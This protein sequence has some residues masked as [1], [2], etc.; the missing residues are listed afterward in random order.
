MRSFS[1]VWLGISLCTIIFGMGLLVIAVASGAEWK[2]AATYPNDAL[3]SYDETYTD[4]KSINMQIEYGEINLVEGDEFSVTADNMLDDDF[5]SYVKDGTWII[6]ENDANDFHIFGFDFSAKQMFRWNGNFT[7]HYTITIPRDFVAEKIVVAIGAGDMVV[8]SINANQGDFTLGAGRITIGELVITEKS[9]YNVG[10]GEMIFENV[11]AN[12]V[13]VECGVGEVDI[14]G[15]ITGEN[16]IHSGVGSVKLELQGNEDDYTYEVN[17]GIGS[18]SI[19]EN[20]YNNVSNEIINNGNGA[21]YLKLD[22]GI[23][24]INIDFY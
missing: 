11:T 14:E 22:C 12:N 18:V 19:G 23:G 17:A 20:S 8:E 3:Y 5:E 15:V 4:V 2:D 6:R 21:N 7:P 24:D 13:S 10:A 9:E 1:K 16:Y